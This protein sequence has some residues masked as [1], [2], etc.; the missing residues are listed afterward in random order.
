[1]V[2][3]QGRVTRFVVM[4]MLQAAR[5]ESL[6]LE[7]DSAL[8]WG[9]NRAIFFA[10]AKQGFKSPPAT[11]TERSEKAPEHPFPEIYRLGNDEAR[12]DPTSKQ[13]V[14]SIGGEN[15]SVETFERQVAARFGTKEHFRLAWAEALRIIGSYDRATL[16]SRQGFYEEV[17]KPRRDELSDRWTQTYSP[18]PKKK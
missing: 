9:L 12:R 17:Y 15:Q 2:R 6:G 8:S 18:P 7:H 3:N 1:M 11:S 16:E 14:F 13:L 5:A 4:A 10:A